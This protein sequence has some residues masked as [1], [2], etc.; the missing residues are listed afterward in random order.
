VYDN[1]GSDQQDQ[2]GESQQAISLDMREHGTPIFLLSAVNKPQD[3][4]VGRGCEEQDQ[5]N[6]VERHGLFMISRF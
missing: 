1:L 4:P 3:K 5:E 2:T 6:L